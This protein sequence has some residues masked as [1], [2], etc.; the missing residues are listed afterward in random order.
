MKRLLR[1]L[2]L[3]LYLCGCSAFHAALPKTEPVRPPVIPMTPVTTLPSIPAAQA[4]STEAESATALSS[5]V[6]GAPTEPTPT[7]PTEPIPWQS[8]D[9][10]PTWKPELAES[11]PADEACGADLLLEK[12]MAVEGLTM[13]DLNERDCRQL[14]LV[15]AQPAEGVETVT[16]CYERSA[17]GCFVPAESLPRMYGFVGKNGIM[18]N[19]RRNTNTSP[20]GLWA[21]GMA[22]GNE[23]PPEH[24]KLPWRQVTPNSDWV[25]DEASP[26]FNTWQE[27]DDPTLIPWGDDVEHLENYPSLYAWACV[28]EFNRPPDVVPNRG[29]A[30]FLHC[31]KAGTGGCIGLRREDMLSV[32]EWLDCGENPYI[33]VTGAECA[34]SSTGSSSPDS[35][36]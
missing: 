35:V 23:A 14:I 10:T 3:L 21:I 6:T 32:L 22:F 15:A 17:E 30:I 12:W 2:P 11:Y 9:T 27:R 16:V 36:A 4:I 20:A 13:A 5:P 1:L 19:R 7:A 29:C 34:A 26:Y 8:G 31:A 24:L 33:L 18:H 25:C 28:I